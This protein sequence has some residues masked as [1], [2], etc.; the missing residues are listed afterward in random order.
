MFWW[1]SARWPHL[2]FVGEDLFAPRGYGIGVEDAQLINGDQI[3]YVLEH[4]GSYRADRVKKL[5]NHVAER[6]LPY[7]LF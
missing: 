6:D 3:V 7:M 2:E 5:H 1:A 4:V